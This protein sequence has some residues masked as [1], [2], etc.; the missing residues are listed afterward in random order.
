LSTINA[1][2]DVRYDIVSYITEW[3]DSFDPNTSTKNNRGSVFVKSI[4]FPRPVDSPYPAA[5]YSFPICVGPSKADRYEVESKFKSELDSLQSDIPLIFFDSTSGTNKTVYVALLCSLQD[6]PERRTSLSLLMGNAKFAPRFGVSL[7]Y[8]LL[9][10]KIV[11]CKQCSLHLLN[12]DFP[13][14][15]CLN[16]VNW[17]DDFSNDLLKINVPKGYPNDC[18]HLTEDKC[19]RPKYIDKQFLIDVVKVAFQKLVTTSWTEKEVLTY[20]NVNGINKEYS[21]LICSL[22]K[23]DDVRNIILQSDSMIIDLYNVM[24]I[25]ST[26]LRTTDVFDHTETIMHLLFLGIVKTVLMDVQ[27]FLK[28]NKMLSS[29]LSEINNHLFPIEQLKL[30]WCNM[31][32]YG[33]GKF[34]G[35]VSENYLA[36]ARIL[37]WYVCIL[38]KYIN[39]SIVDDFVLLRNV[40]DTLSCLLSRC[41]QRIVNDKLC[42]SVERHVKIFLNCYVLMDQQLNGPDSHSWISKYNFLSLLNLHKQIA[43]YGPLHNMWEGSYIGEKIITLLKPEITSGLRKNWSVNV[44]KKYI[45]KLFFGVMEVKYNFREPK[46]T[47]SKKRYTTFLEIEHRIMHSLPIVADYCNY[48]KVLY[49]SFDNGEVFIGSFIVGNSINWGS[50]MYF[51]ISWSRWLGNSEEWNVSTECLLLPCPDVGNMFPDIENIG[52][53]RYII[54]SDWKEFGAEF[55][56][57]L[58]RNCLPQTLKATLGPVVYQIG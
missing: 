44:Y 26:W 38:E 57:S 34:G 35:H 6:Q 29:F 46:V 25:P 13:P 17:C 40:I 42:R 24:K 55:E 49:I 10:S 27:T 19:L 54:S 36:M 18:H 5:C 53:F 56:P 41:L 16:C 32:P 50:T 9:K 52:R 31:I 20:L 3:S 11:S 23:N 15:T 37:K 30:N 47:G 39:Q 12:G 58:I 28:K 33:S 21:D 1:L 43:N 4:T 22:S 51:D 7:P 48:Q 14:V 8:S 2:P 45:R